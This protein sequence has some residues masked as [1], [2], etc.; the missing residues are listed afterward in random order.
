MSVLIEIDDLP[1]G[2]RLE[3]WRQAVKIVVPSLEVTLRRGAAAQGQI[4]LTQAGEVGMF[5]VASVAQTIERTE[6]GTRDGTDKLFAGITLRGKG[7]ARQDDRTA[8]IVPGA[9]AFYDA[10]RPYML[11]FT[12]D[13]QVLAVELPRS[14]LLSRFGPTALYTSTSIGEAH[15]GAAI[16]AFFREF[17]RTVES[18]APAQAGSLVSLGVDLLVDGLA[19]RLAEEPVVPLLD[20]L[21]MHKIK[22]F[23][24]AHVGEHGLDASAMARAGGVSATRLHHLFRASGDTPASYL[25]RKR[26]ALARHRLSQA[27]TGGLTI[28]TVAWGCGFA[29]QAH[30]SRRF[31]E[32]YGE[33]PL[34]WRDRCKVCKA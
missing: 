25:W 16:A 10:S 7:T 5:A 8:D 23:V 18:M 11:D 28:G 34:E 26:L 29:S 2:S 24:D 1:A 3:T 6:A 21:T 19:G 13:F 32:A 17:A 15:G 30:F 12:D 14:R 27:A 4:A 31:K 33:T 22:G 9:V 20:A